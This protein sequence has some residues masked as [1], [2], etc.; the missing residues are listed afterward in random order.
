MPYYVVWVG[1]EPGIYDNWNDCRKRIIGFPGARYKKF[2]TL[3]EAEEAFGSSRSS[4]PKAVKLSGSESPIQDALAVDAA[5][6]G[7]PG[8]MEYRGVHVGSRQE[9]FN[10]KIELGTNNIGEFL[11]IVHAL[12]LYKIRGLDWPVYSDSHNAILWVKAGRC[13]TKLVRDSNTEAVF[14][15]IDSAEKWLRENRFTNPILKWDTSKW[16]EIPADFGRK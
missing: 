7:N 6:S 11:A 8:V 16:G 10:F 4:K 1:A 14:E 5:C 3:A 2:N 13:K 15:R 9:W 12:A